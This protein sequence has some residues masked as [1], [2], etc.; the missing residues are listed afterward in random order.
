MAENYI[1]YAFLT[2]NSFCSGL[3][4]PPAVNIGDMENKGFD[5]TLNYNNTALNNDLSYN[6]GLTVST[7][8]NKIISIS[9]NPKE[10]I[11]GLAYRYQ[12]YTRAQAGT[13]YPEFYGLIVDGIFQTQEE[14]SAHPAIFG[15]AYNSPGHFKYRDV[16]GPDGAPDG[17]VNAY[18][19]TY[20]GSPHPKFTAGFNMDVTYKAF[21]SQ[22]LPLFKLWQQSCRL[23]RKMEELWDILL[24]S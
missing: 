21:S 11:S 22:R 20:I 6:L 8:K 4:A 24:Q 5:L 10:F 23:Y 1:R 2:E 18:D 12:I 19:N 9:D 3:A 13:A 16:S 7:Y 15:G 14:A 17:I